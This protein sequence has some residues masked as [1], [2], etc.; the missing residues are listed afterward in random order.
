MLSRMTGAAL[1]LL[2]GV[3]V[4]AAA[5]QA[6]ARTSATARTPATTAPAQNTANKVVVYKSP[7]CGCCGQWVTYMRNNGF[8][9]E[10]H[11]QDDVSPIKQ[12][13]GVPQALQS[14]HTA[15]VGGYVVEGHVP[16]EAIRRL[17]RERPQITGIAVG[18]MVTGTPGMEMGSRKDP[19][20]VMAFTRDGRTSV[21]EHH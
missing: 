14:C 3:T 21:Y 11:D 19:Y 4:S 12:A 9:V 17:L 16:V 5:Q 20:D 6:P 2:T 18:G 1:A 7:T 15:Q 13:S 8:T 10:V